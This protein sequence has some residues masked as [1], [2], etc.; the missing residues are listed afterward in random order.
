MM[1]ILSADLMAKIPRKAIKELVKSH[2]KARI[3]EGGAEKMAA[4]LEKEAERMSAFAVQN[5]KRDRR[6]KITR[7]DIEE[8]MLRK[9][10]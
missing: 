9:A 2:F 3:T 4:M 1:R 10:D 6:V 7:K 5:A 8:Y